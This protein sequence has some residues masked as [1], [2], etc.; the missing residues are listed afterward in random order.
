MVVAIVG[1]YNF[2][3]YGVWKNKPVGGIF[4]DTVC[5]MGDICGLSYID[6]CYIEL[7]V[8]HP[9][10]WGGISKRERV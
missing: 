5:F 10:L 3:D 7:I 2:N 8:V 6:D 1:A 4:A 9:P